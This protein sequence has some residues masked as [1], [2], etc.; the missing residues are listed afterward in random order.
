MSRRFD[1]GVRMVRPFRACAAAALIVVSLAGAAGCA[2]ASPVGPSLA[3]TKSPVQLL[4]NEAAS[5]I[6][7]AAIEAVSRTDD[8][9]ARCDT[10]SVDPEGLRR[11][12]RSSTEVTVEAAATWRV[13]T[14]V[15]DIGQSFAEQGWT[16]TPVAAH[17]GTHA[18]TLHRD[19]SA[20]DIRISAHRPDPGTE[21]TATDAEE[22]VT[23]EVSTRGPCV[24]TEGPDSDAVKKLEAQN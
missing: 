17:D 1:E 5:R 9:S 10:E 11:S 14:I 7:P 20:S 16:V 19:G 13:D 21:P 6:P 2:Q 3:D 18:L 12:W 22:P 4:R 8:R 23:I 24:D 15:D